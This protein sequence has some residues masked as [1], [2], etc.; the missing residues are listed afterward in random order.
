MNNKIS[1]ADILGVCLLIFLISFAIYESIKHNATHINIE[2][3]VISKK[4]ETVERAILLSGG[5]DK[6][7]K[8]YIFYEEGYYEIVSF[9]KYEQI[10][11]GDV[12]TI[13]SHKKN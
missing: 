1:I 3:E 2:V 5:I 11:I 12:K 10:K 6:Y 7:N 4:I 9:A 8:Y 13:Q